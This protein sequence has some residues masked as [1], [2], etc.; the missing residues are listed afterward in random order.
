M[1]ASSRALRPGTNAV[2]LGCYCALSFLSFGLPVVAHPG[3][4]VIGRI[5]DTNIYVWSFAW[6][7]HA[8]LHGENPIFTHAIWAPSGID[9][10]W[11]TIAPA[12]ALTFAPLTLVAGPVVAYNTA[13]VLLPALAAWTGFLL[14]RYLTRSTWPSILGGYLFGFSSYMLGQE[15]GAHLQMTSVFLVPLFTLVILRYAGG[16]LDSRALALR[17]GAL[18]GVQVWLS[19]EI[20]ATLSLALAWSLVL[21]FVLFR[22]ARPRLRSLARP[23]ALAYALA[24]LLASP[25]LYYALTDFHSGSLNPPGYYSADLANFVIPTQTV[26]AGGSLAREISARFPANEFEQGAYLGLPTLVIAVLFLWGRRR[27]PTARFLAVSLAA[28]VVAALGTALYVAGHR[29]VPLPW[30]LLVGLPVFSNILPVRLML[31]AS[32]AAAVVVAFWAASS[33]SRVL[34]IA[35]A[36]L[37]AAALVPTL[38]AQR[39]SRTPSL[40]DFFA[41]GYYKGCLEPGENVLVLPYN[42]QAESVYWQAV[43]DFQFRMPGGQ[44]AAFTPDEFAGTTVIRMLHNHSHSEDGPAIVDFARSKGVTM[45]LVDPTDPWPWPTILRNLAKPRSVGGLLLYPL[46][47]GPTTRGVCAPGG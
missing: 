34:R 24:A 45:I 10:A 26:A 17:L 6:W 44:I 15:S 31:Y 4:T 9:L 19:T 36:A 7:P 2:A 35:L 47:Q 5:T 12:L 8:I 18:L 20:F 42:Y 16:A 21:A 27:D 39:W 3:R 30:R 43:A 1:R 25:L 28:A 32:L 41:K 29:V 37:A 38:D 14:C 40:P 33:A 46:E 13:A 23:L 22:P 11:T